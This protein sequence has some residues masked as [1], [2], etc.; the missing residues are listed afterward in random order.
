MADEV[1]TVINT[2][3]LTKIYHGRQIALNCV[4]LQVE[5]GT[6]LG[7]LGSNGAGKTTLV[8]LLMGLQVP[9]AGK[10]TILGQRM[11][12]NAAALRRRIG[13][14]SGDPKFPPQMSAI[15]YLDFVGRLSGLTHRYR[16]PR[17]A[18]LLRAV[19]LLRVAGDPIRG[20][21]AG[22]RTRLAIAASLI[23]DPE[24][25]IWD[26]PSQ[27]LDPE[28]RRSMLQ[29]MRNL[30]ESK[31]LLLC[32]HNLTEIQDVCTRAIVMHQGQII[33]NGE[34]EELQASLRPSQIELLL[35][36]DKK[37]IATATKTI[38]QLDELESCVLNRNQMTLVIKAG[39]S[40]ATALANVLVTL[41]DHKIEMSNMRV[42]GP[43]TEQ[44][45][46]ELIMEE[47]NRGLTRAHQPVAG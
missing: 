1:G 43:Q 31:T 32:S 11:G 24:L 16:R 21:S 42:S 19:D 36:G 41:A 29:L 44:A 33:F 7:I 3:S 8:R 47:G 34:L 25:L 45:L 35:A 4:D 22:M 6:V 20:Y 37:E 15:D 12:P 14:L 38:Q 13:F 17:L 30:S 10:V 18:S 9:T 46:A 39:A 27:G 2:E 28:A 23:N 5:A 26:E 40:H